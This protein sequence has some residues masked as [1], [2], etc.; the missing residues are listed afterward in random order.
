MSLIV[1]AF[2]RTS[3][4]DYGDQMD[5]ADLKDQFS[6]R[7]KLFELQWNKVFETNPRAR[8]ENVEERVLKFLNRFRKEDRW[9]NIGHMSLVGTNNTSVAPI[10]AL[11]S[12]PGNIRSAGMLW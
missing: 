7:R 5:K 9:Y 4:N 1:Y 11:F 6:D 3:C 2:G 10:I 8:V 12:D